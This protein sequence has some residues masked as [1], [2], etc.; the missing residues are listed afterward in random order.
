MS[1]ASHFTPGRTS[2]GPVTSGQRRKAAAALD[3]HIAKSRRCSS[4][5]A[6]VHPGWLFTTVYCTKCGK[7]IA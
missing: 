2:D 3:Q 7:A 4:A 5:D 1:H 6:C